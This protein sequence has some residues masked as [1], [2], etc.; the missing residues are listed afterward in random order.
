MKPSLGRVVHYCEPSNRL[1]KEGEKPD[2][3]VWQAALVTGINPAILPKDAPPHGEAESISL[4]YFP[5]SGGA[6]GVRKVFEGKEAGT[7][8]WP[9]RES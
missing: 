2:P 8:R 3:P 1:P 5:R 4:T 9:P 7:W 6:I